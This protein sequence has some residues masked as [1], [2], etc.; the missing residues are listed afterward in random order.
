M[1]DRAFEQVSLIAS[2]WVHDIRPTTL[3]PHSADRLLTS[4]PTAV[5]ERHS[6]IGA[7]RRPPWTHTGCRVGRTLTSPVRISAPSTRP[8]DAAHP[9]P[10][11]PPVPLI[12]GRSQPWHSPVAP[13]NRSRRSG[14]YYEK[15]K[16]ESRPNPSRT[17]PTSSTPSG[18]RAHAGSAWVSGDTEDGT[19][20]ISVDQRT[21]DASNRRLRR[22]GRAYEQR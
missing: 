6:S 12:A 17:T 18:P 19:Y 15:R 14:E 22:P 4:R 3:A 11:M 13:G 7:V 2:N 1:A 8:A 21:E 10:G 20:R 9:T 16:I 5:D